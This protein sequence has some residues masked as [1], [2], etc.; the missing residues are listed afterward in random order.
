MS[1]FYKVS[2]RLG[3]H[4]WEDLA[5]HPPFADQ[6]LSLVA[7]DE[8]GVE[9]PY[10]R[11]LDLGQP[12]VYSIL[13]FNEPNALDVQ[14]TGEFEIEHDGLLNALR[15]ITKSVLAVLQQKSSTIDWLNHY[16]SLPLEIPREVRKGDLL[17][18]SFA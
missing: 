15:F 3:F 12:H 1:L 8:H 5:A 11:A 2:Y 9:P 7:R 18:V 17:Q 16:M 13:D 6:L 4:P 14:W 10:G